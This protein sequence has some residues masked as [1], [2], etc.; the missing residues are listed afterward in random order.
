MNDYD[1]NA[2]EPPPAGKF[3]TF[4]ADPPWR[5]GNTSTRGAAENH[6]GTMSIEELCEYF[7][8]SCEQKGCYITGLPDWS[9]L[10]ERLPRRI[11]PTDIDAG[12]RVY[13]RS[14]T[15]AYWSRWKQAAPG[16]AGN[17]NRGPDH[18]STPTASTLRRNHG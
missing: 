15:T 8:H 17:A 6:Y 18:G 14:Q 12:R 3:S 4:V 10:I 16:R 13:N 9:E 2:P 11:R 5:Y 1:D 7:R